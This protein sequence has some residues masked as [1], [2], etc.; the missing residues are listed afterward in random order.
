MISGL[1]KI[2]VT[3]C[4]LKS[5]VHKKGRRVEKKRKKKKRNTGETGE[6]WGKSWIQH[7]HANCLSPSSPP[8]TVRLN[9][10][11]PAAPES[12]GVAGAVFPDIAIAPPSQTVLRE[13]VCILTF[14][15]GEG[16]LV[17]VL[18]ALLALMLGHGV[19]RVEAEPLLVVS[20]GRHPVL[21]RA[22]GRP[23]EEESA[24]FNVHNR[25]RELP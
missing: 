23:S 21:L 13:S 1:V 18:G 16:L 14:E 10:H 19:R 12:L 5:A 20:L 6:L 25:P 17:A 9:E 15:L 3:P 8:P 7:P 2:N 24:S 4:E 22:P 11:R